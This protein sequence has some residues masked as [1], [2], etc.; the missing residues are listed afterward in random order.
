MTFRVKEKEITAV[1]YSIYSAIFSFRF[2]V[3]FTSRLQAIWKYIAKLYITNCVLLF[4]SMKP[5]K[6]PCCNLCSSDI[7]GLGRSL[8]VFC[9]KAYN[10]NHLRNSLTHDPSIDV[11]KKPTELLLLAPPAL[12]NFI[13]SHMILICVQP[14][15]DLRNIM[16]AVCTCLIYSYFPIHKGERELPLSYYISLTVLFLF[17][18]RALIIVKQSYLLILLLKLF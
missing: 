15:I 11:Y 1:L 12:L 18:L 9:Q 2:I 16:F 8:T 17:L 7:Q 4:V 13:V 5:Y 10:F 14:L 6:G 3:F